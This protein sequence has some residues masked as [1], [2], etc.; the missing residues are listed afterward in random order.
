MVNFVKYVFLT[1]YTIQEI[2]SIV[3]KSIYALDFKRE[4]SELYSPI[5]YM[6]SI[7]GKRIRPTLC[8][9]TYSLFSDTIE[10][11]IVF[12]ALGLEVFHTFTLIHDDIMDKSDMRRGQ[13]TVHKKWNDNI[14]ILSA[15][16]MCIESYK[17]ISMA[18]SDKLQAALQLFTKTGLEICEG[19]QLDMNY[20]NISIITMDEYLKMIGLKT[21][22]LLACS[23]KMGAILGGAEKNVREAIYQYGWLLGLAFQITD[24]YL[25]TFG[26]P[27]V[28][29]KKIGGDIVNNKKSWLCVE[30][31]RLAT[32]AKKEELE[33][34]M[35]MPI[36]KSD[37]KIAAMQNLYI[38]LGIKESAEKTIEQYCNEAMQKIEELSLGNEKTELLREFAN[39][40]T[41]RTK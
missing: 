36:E 34:I 29:G 18:P 13:L 1:M 33:R 7:G 2:Q 12:P 6:M 8:L 16:A 32:G 20:E 11:S 9:L 41:F 14:A 4:P 5:E 15:D 3:K 37:E 24:D 31:S 38:D 25:D 21:S 35:A 30:S 26:N 39:Q 40:I 10:N 23:S 27:A 19:Q 22:A 17:Y 28:F